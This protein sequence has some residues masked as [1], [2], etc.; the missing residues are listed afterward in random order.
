M[1]HGHQAAE[2]QLG[3]G[4]LGHLVGGAGRSLGGRDLEG[5][6]RSVDGHAVRRGIHSDEGGLALRHLARELG[7]LAGGG[8]VGQGLDGGS[9]RKEN[10]LS[11]R[12]DG[13]GAVR[14]VLD[15]G[16][17]DDIAGKRDIRID[18]RNVAGPG[19]IGNLDCIAAGRQERQRG[20]QKN[21]CFFHIA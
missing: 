13:L 18:D 5:Y 14:K 11:L 4:S 3:A 7:H 20:N 10:G 12:P 8:P 6:G 16:R 15:G 17:E 19:N 2:V 1:D 21:Q 9:V